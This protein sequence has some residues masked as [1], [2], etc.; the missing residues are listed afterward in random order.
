MRVFSYAV[1]CL[2]ARYTTESASLKSVLFKICC[3]LDGKDTKVNK[4]LK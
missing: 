1:L 3:A 2:V 4:S